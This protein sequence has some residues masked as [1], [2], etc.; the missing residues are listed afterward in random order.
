[1]ST[2]P[3]SNYGWYHRW[4]QRE[5]EKIAVDSACDELER[6]SDHLAESTPFGQALRNYV[7]GIIGHPLHWR[8]VP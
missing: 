6:Q 1:M 7:D 3:N 5:E 4:T 2:S 8:M